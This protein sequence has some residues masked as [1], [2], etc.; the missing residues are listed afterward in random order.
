M[1]TD[2]LE[3]PWSMVWLP[4]SSI[5][6]TERSGRLRYIKNGKLNPKPVQGLPKVF[7]EGQGGLMDISIHPDFDENRKVYFTFSSGTEN[8]NQTVVATAV[9]KDLELQNVEIIFRAEPV[10]SGDQHF[11]SRILWL[12]DG[13]FLISIGDGG[14]RPQSIDGVLSREYAQMKDAH[15]GKVL[16]FNDDG[17]APE[18]NPFADEESALSEIWTL[19]HRNIQ[20]LAINTETGHV[21]AN[22]HGS[23]GGDELNLLEAGKNYGW[24]VVTYSREYYGP[25]IT[26]E[27]TK[28]GMVDPR[29]VWT[30]AQAPSGLTFYTGRHF[31]N[32]QGN[33]FSG[34][35]A[36][37]QIRRIILED[38]EVTG[39]E[40]LTIGTRIRDVKQGPDD[41]LYF[42]TDEENGRLIRIVPEE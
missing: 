21:W 32:W 25:R 20:G 4:D 15:L 5:L 22:E 35:L 27:T 39:E 12:A 6:V 19:G 7:A 11:G 37:Q 41:Y 30:P 14:N 18:D 3:H 13:T 34:G 42:L 33:L 16:R 29:V 8:Q 28:P 10:K 36:G 2:G 31:P 9:L 26:S 17:S 24:P 23:K 38:E 1:V 40:S